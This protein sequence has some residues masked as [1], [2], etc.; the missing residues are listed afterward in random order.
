MTYSNNTQIIY[1]ILYL[2]FLSIFF[3]AIIYCCYKNSQQYR[4][5]PQESHLLRE[6]E[7]R[8]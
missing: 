4:L 5:L 2:G 7:I 1:G 3:C 8:L 6:N